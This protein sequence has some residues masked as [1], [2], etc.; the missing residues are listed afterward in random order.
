M[1]GNTPQ[2]SSLNLPGYTPLL[3]LSPLSV[4]SSSTASTV[5]QPKSKY[6]LAP[7][8]SEGG[9]TNSP[10]EKRI[11]AGIH[12]IC[13]I[14]AEADEAEGLLAALE[15]DCGS[16]IVSL[17][18]QEEVGGATGYRHYQVYVRFS[19]K[20]RPV[21]TYRTVKTHWEP[22]RN[23]AKAIL[24][25][26]KSDTR[27]PSGRCFDFGVPRRLF[28][29]EISSLRPAQ[30]EIVD[31]LREPAGPHDRRVM[32]YW[33]SEGNWGKSWVS[34]VIVDNFKAIVIGGSAKDALYGVASYVEN[35]GEGPD[36]V[37]FDIPR[38][39]KDYV[40]YQSIEKIKDGLFFSAKYESCQ[41]RFNTPHVI[42]FANSEPDVSQLSMD[43]WSIV[44][45]RPAAELSLG[46]F[47]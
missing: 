2:S 26:R 18:Y 1:N 43:R 46:D 11:N 19:K 4:R 5:I 41:V 16:K 42:C 33:E 36:I 32:W 20:I 6:S 34:K 10:S 31:T 24:Y 44:P 29:A 3:E 14:P 12:W 7:S 38:C 47:C 40:S 21:E 27:V 22:A 30:K 8:G 9:N 23:P 15:A 45:L 13:T 35:H 28:R 37:V 39:T 25:S 17:T